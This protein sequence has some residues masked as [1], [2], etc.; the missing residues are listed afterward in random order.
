MSTMNTNRIQRFARKSLALAIASI[1][2]IAANAQSNSETSTEEVEEILVK[3][4]N[5]SRLRALEEKQNDSRLI[6]ALGIDELGQFPDRN[7]GESLNRL[8]G[9]SMLVEKGEGRFVQ[10]RGINPALNNVTINGVQLG[11]PEQEGGGR[12]A[13]MDVISGGILGGVQVVKTPTAD[14]DSQGI[15]GTVNVETTMPFDRNE[16]FYGYMTTRLGRE[17]VRPE[18]NAFGG[19]DPRALD[20]LVSGKFA[21]NTIGWLLGAT[22]SDREYIAQGI[23]QDDWDPSNGNGLP[24]NVKNNYYI[25]GRERINANAVLE[26]RPDNNSSYFLRGFYAT[27]D[28]YQHR[29]R[30]E[31]GLSNDVVATSTN[32]G[33]SGGNRIASNI[34]LEEAKKDLFSFAVGGEN[35]INAFTVNYLL[36]ANSNELDEPNDYWEFRSGSSAFGPNS[37]ML[38]G[39]GVVT[40]T[41]QTGSPNRQDPSLIPLRRVRFFER[42][43]EENANIAKIDLQWDMDDSTF[44]KTGIKYASTDRTLDQ[45]RQ[46][47]NPGA[48]DLNLGTSSQF[49]NGSFFNDVDSY[50]VPNIWMD[51][52]GMNS[53]FDNSANADYFEADIGDNFVADNSADYSVDETVLATYIM[54]SKTFDNLEVIAGVRFEQTDIESRGNLLSGGIASPVRG[55]SDYSNVMPSLLL[56]YRISDSFVG[57]AGITRALGR[58]DFGTIAPRSTLNDDG[59]PIASIN[60][61]NPDLKPR[62]STNYDLA[63]EWYPNS[64]SIISLSFFYKDISEELI[65]LTTSLTSSTAMDAALAARGLSGVVDT[66]SLSRLDLSTTINASSATLKGFEFLGQTQLSFLPAPLNDLG[67]SATITSLDGETDL[68]SGTIPLIGQPESTYAFSMFYQNGKLDAAINYAYNDSFLTDLNDDPDLVLDQGEFGRLDAR[69]AYSVNDSLKIFLEGVNLN[70]EPTSEFQGGRSNWNTEYEYVG[71]TYYLGMSYGF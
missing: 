35:V 23:F 61:G 18:S 2:S 68:P 26:I 34:R 54:G 66:A 57:R 48:L 70:D 44:L 65:G 38:D 50:D 19:D 59:G 4:T 13:P 60:I 27:W 6:D 28:E 22:W 11:S 55:S 52:D 25:I 10:I 46:R 16:E 5:L 7:V 31:Q 39:D 42:A 32:A 3:G 33:T 21:D 15:G 43:V 14:M 56:N 17:S 64:L 62:E 30:F 20:A 71:R 47:F 24:V 8:P 67:V 53:F 45:S 12:A 51:I 49:T 69:I 40:I 41:P 37:W 36:Q 1:V 9:V 58:P 63:L 29:N